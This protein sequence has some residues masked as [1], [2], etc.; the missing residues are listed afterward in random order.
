M[1]RPKLTK[2]FWFFFS[3][4]NFLPLFFFVLASSAQA[5][6]AVLIA[7]DDS[8]PVFD[9][10]IEAVRLELKF[11]QARLLRASSGSATLSSVLAAIRGMRPAAGEGC[12]VFATSHGVRHEGFYLAQR[13]EVLTPAA[14]DRALVQG[15]GTA[16]TVVV[17]SSCFSGSFAQGPMMRVNRIILTAARADRTSFGCQ[18][19]RDFTVYDACFL[20]AVGRQ[21]R[22][23]RVYADVKACVRREER[24]DGETPSEPQG[25]FGGGVSDEVN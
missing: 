20:Q 1:T 15:C 19:G 8:L 12:F 13:D 24:A 23:R 21:A 7:G 17:V 25:W 6:P 11:S 5:S 16:R 2:V 18:A 3:K 10:A 14:L 22:W 9:H 4:K